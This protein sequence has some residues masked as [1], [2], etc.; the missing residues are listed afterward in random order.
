MKPLK[1][2]LVF[3]ALLD[4]NTVLLLQIDMATHPNFPCI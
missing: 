4:S 3:K 1:F 2:L